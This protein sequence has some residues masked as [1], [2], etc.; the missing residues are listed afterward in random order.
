MMLRIHILHGIVLL[1]HWG[2]EIFLSFQQAL[3]DAGTV[4][5]IGVTVAQFRAG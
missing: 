5:T 4:V 1:L 2:N 3:G